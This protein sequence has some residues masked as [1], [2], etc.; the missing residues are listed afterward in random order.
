MN[1][2][3]VFS[4]DVHTLATRK[5]R[6]FRHNRRGFWVDGFFSVLQATLAS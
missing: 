3:S 2:G 1:L 5:Q 6:S 4:R